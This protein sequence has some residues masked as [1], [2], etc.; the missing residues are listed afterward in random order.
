MIV[1]LT[2]QSGREDQMKNAHE[3]QDKHSENVRC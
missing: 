1:E 2:L 3:A